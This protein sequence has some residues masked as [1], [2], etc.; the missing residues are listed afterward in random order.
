MITGVCYG[1]PWMFRS[2]VSKL[3]SELHAARAA[4]YQMGPAN[5]GTLAQPT[6]W[7]RGA[8]VTRTFYL[9]SNLRVTDI[10]F[11]LLGSPL[12]TC[13]LF[14]VIKIMGDWHSNYFFN[15]LLN[16]FVS[17]QMSKNNSCGDWEA[18]FDSIYSNFGRVSVMNPRQMTVDAPVLMCHSSV[19][20]I[21]MTLIMNENYGQTFARDSKYQIRRY[22]CL[23]SLFFEVN[24]WIKFLHVI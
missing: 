2:T 11:V 13:P 16:W 17:S 24:G 15:T 22:L 14:S 20:L 21:I 10:G 6:A 3:W 1:V 5:R 18:N 9:R 8:A 19:S 4:S 12:S 23:R 7:R